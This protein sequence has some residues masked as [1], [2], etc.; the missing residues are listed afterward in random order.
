MTDL[1][2]PHWALPIPHA[3]ADD[4]TAPGRKPVGPAV[5]ITDAITPV[6]GE[7]LLSLMMKRLAEHKDDPEG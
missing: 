2:V 4:R 6:A 1:T 3:S 7:T 5:I